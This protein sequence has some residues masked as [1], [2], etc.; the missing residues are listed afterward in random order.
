MLNDFH[1]FD[2]D[3]WLSYKTL[4]K[5]HPDFDSIKMFLLRA[6]RVDP[7]YLKG[8]DET[9]FK[10]ERDLL[11]AEW[12]QKSEEAKQVGTTAHEMIHNMF[13]T[14]LKDVKKDLGVDTD[15]YQVQKI[16]NFLNTEKGIFPEFR[17]EIPIDE[18]VLIGVPDLVIKDGNRISII[19][20]KTNESIKFKS[21]FEVGKKRTKKMKYP[22]SKFD[23]CEGIRYQ[24]Q[25]SLYAKMIQRL[26]PKLEIGQLTI[27]QIENLKK[28][29]EFPVAY[30]EDEVENLINYY[31][32]H[33]RLENEFKKCRP[34]QY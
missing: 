20:W 4:E 30:L 5:L 10:T 22:L 15:L 28:K 26:D 33:T 9:V 6:K 16:D 2:S 32:K 19:D 1:V 11:E 25:L 24:L 29:K 17:I 12:K 3:F 34:I 21:I 27:V 14:N 7:K 23:D 18:F 13:C 31:I 8:I